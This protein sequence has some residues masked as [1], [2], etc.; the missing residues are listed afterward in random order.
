MQVWFPI[1]FPN[2]PGGGG[3]EGEGR[4]ETKDYR[5]PLSKN[6]P[7]PYIAIRDTFVLTSFSFKSNYCH[8]KPH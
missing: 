2:W 5:W 1:L 7:S 6:I 3:T 8:A 4:Q